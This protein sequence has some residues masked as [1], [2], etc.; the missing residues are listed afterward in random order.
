MKFQRYSIL[1]HTWGSLGT[2]SFLIYSI[3]ILMPALTSV[4]VGLSIRTPIKFRSNVPC[5]EC[6]F[7]ENTIQYLDLF[8]LVPWTMTRGFSKREI[9]FLSWIS[10]EP[11]TRL[12][13]LLMGS[14]GGFGCDFAKVLF[15]NRCF[16]SFRCFKNVS[17]LD[18]CTHIKGSSWWL[19]HLRGDN[20]QI[21]RLRKWLGL[22]K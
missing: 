6:I 4:K 10:I 19:L 16:S 9:I 15:P 3:T 1:C 21:S 20:F 13:T 5:F 18:W 12:R 7:Y 17:G 22:G 8:D 2:A 11:M 14:V